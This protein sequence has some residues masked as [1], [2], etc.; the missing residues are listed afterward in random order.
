MDAINKMLVD[1]VVIHAAIAIVRFSASGTNACIPSVISEKQV[2][3]VHKN[4]RFQNRFRF[5][6]LVS[7]SE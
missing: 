5:L 6:C 1:K 4:K 2:D 7:L 3:I